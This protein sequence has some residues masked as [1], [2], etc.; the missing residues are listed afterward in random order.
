[1]TKSI[2]SPRA[3]V[4]GWPVSHSRSP[5]IHGYWLK[6]LAIAGT[7][8]LFKVAPG[9]FAEFVDRIGRDGL[10]GCNVTVPH[11]E[12]AFAA[13]DCH[14]PVAAAL[15]AVNTLWREGGLLWGDNTDVEG[16]LANMD[17]SAPGWRGRRGSAV[18]IGAGGA[19]RAI[20]YGLASRGFRRIAIVNRTHARAVA[21]AT[22]F[23]DVAIATPWDSLSTELPSCDLLVNTSCLGMI[24]QPPLEMDL[25]AI[26]QAAVVSDIVYA[27]FR[28]PL[29]KSARAHGFRTAEGLGML[30]HQAVPAFERLFGRRPEVTPGL[31]ALIE[32]DVLAAHEDTR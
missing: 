20:V 23:S 2:M 24:G 5:L 29:V 19:A 6:T 14:T 11:K 7:Y 4:V 3:G 18:V 15:K 32:A 12:V 22:E 31:R 26:P 25:S 9:E 27:P 16:F 30:L 1:M 10:I 28:T 17:E 13:C 8:E 21:L